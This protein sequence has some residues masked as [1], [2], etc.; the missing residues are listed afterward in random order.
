MITESTAYQAWIYSQLEPEEKL[1]VGRRPKK[2]TP[3]W[4]LRGPSRDTLSEKEVQDKE[5]Q[6]LRDH[7]I[8]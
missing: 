6:F 4:M 2:E 1:F 8:L 5:D 3:T 7:G